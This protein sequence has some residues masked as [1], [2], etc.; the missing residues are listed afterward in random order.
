MK[1]LSNTL[2]KRIAM[3]SPNTLSP[4]QQIVSHT[5][6]LEIFTNSPPPHASVGK[7]ESL[8]RFYQRLCVCASSDFHP[9][10]KYGRM[11]KS[12]V[13]GSI[14]LNWAIRSEKSE[15]NLVKFWSFKWV[16]R[17]KIGV[18]REWFSDSLGKTKIGF[19]PDGE[20]FPTK[21]IFSIFP[22]SMSD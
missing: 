1:N 2:K 12:P 5:N 15:E 9:H 18:R 14:F 19:Y 16:K 17:S 8:Y 13:A 3:C 6:L 11:R 20:C 10:K 7:H 22:S 21:H 4:W